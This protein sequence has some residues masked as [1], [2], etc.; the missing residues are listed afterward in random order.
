[1]D[2]SV[3]TREWVCRAAASPRHFAAIALVA[4]LAAFV[5]LAPVR[6]QASSPGDL[7][8][9]LNA[10]SEFDD[11]LS[12]ASPEEQEF[13]R[14]N[15][16]RM[17]GYAPYFNQALP[18]APP[19]HFY[20]DLYAIY[21][22]EPDDQALLSA[23]PDWVLRDAQGNK[24]Y[25]Q[26]DCN[27]TTCT[28]YAADVGNPAWRAHWIDDAKSTLA[29]GYTGIFVDDVNMEMKVS[30]GAGDFV[31]PIDPRTGQPMTDES[32]RRYVAEFTE[33]IRA[34]LPD[35]EIVHNS[36][37][38][39]D[40]SDPYVQRQ[41][42]AADYI[43]LERGFADTGIVGGTGEWSYEN[44]LSYVEWL[45]SQGAGAVYEPYDLDDQSRLFEMASYFLV[46][47]GNDSISSEYETEPGDWWS[48]WATDL[49]DATTGRREWKGLLRR[50]FAGGMVLVSEPEADTTT[51]KLPRRVW[52][53]PNG[54]RVRR[55]VSLGERTGLVL[56][57]GP[58]LGPRK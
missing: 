27:G 55:R 36:L 30:N 45:H 12:S 16:W 37:W 32:W 22:S 6:A 3:W 39:M 44:Y 2:C 7:N 9:Q 35:A 29:L 31:R 58:K 28:Q 26:F 51:V 10:E 54:E 47:N 24:L 33:Q 52:T 1:M 14:E 43:D 56:I 46:S 11:T 53:D 57:R 17:R 15:Y 21:R 48:G 8:I 42:A 50:D 4:I 13:M 19:S 5:A 34:A 25:I 38:W 40:R 20:K 23:H 18:W 49:G 41:V